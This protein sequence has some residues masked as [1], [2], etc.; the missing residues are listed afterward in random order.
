MKPEYPNLCSPIKIGNVTFRNRMFSAPMGATEITADHCITYRTQG[1]YELRAKGGAAAVTMSELCVH[2]KTD[3]T[4]MIHADPAVS[5]SLGGLAFA[6]DGIRRHGA[7]PSIQ[8]SH[9][10]Q[11]ARPHLPASGEPVPLYGPV[12][13]VLPDGAQ[14]KGLTKMQIEDIVEGYGRTAQ[15]VKRA[16]FEMVMVHVGH[17]WLL[18]Q[19]LSPRFNKREDEYGGSFENR[20]RIVLGA[21]KSI[22]DAVGPGFPIEAR[23]SGDEFIEGGYHI[24]EGCRIAHAVEDYVDLIHVSAG[25]HELSFHRMFPSMFLEHGCNVRL[26]AEVKKHVSKPVATLGA[27]S[28]PKQMEEILA[29]GKADVIYMARQLLADPEFP[30][31]VAA[32]RGD[33]AIKCIRCLYCMA[34]RRVTQTRRCSLEPRIGREFE[35]MNVALAPNPKKVLVVGGGIGGM[36]AA[37]TAASRGHKV[38]LCEKSGELGG[39]LKCEQGIPFKYEMYELTQSFNKLLIKEGVDIRLNTEVDSAYVEKEGVDALIIAV[40]SNPIIPPLPGIDGDNVVIVNN[41]HLEKNK[42][43]DTVAVLGGGLAGSECAIHLAHCGKKVILVEMA[44]KIA[45]DANA[46]H[47]PALLNEIEKYGIDVRTKFKGEFISSEGLT[48]SNNNSKVLIPCDTVIC[49]VGQRPCREVV[50]E[51]RYS[52]PFVRE[53]G[54]CVKAANVMFA[55]YQGYHAAMDL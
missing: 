14:V 40:G 42:V 20:I 39:L 1:F 50:D 44:D 55:T 51:L 54:D 8:L 32:G 18:N 36:K 26:A 13:C 46:L 19:F 31:K 11:I 7:I 41:Y 45:Q 47:R 53:I 21:L 15:F 34:E 16:G 27:L 33:E 52:A 43:G 9:A 25:H 49:A 6:A 4:H 29:S 48:C 30:N 17:G 2:P 10:G 35:D 23:I 22:R 37:F 24:D 3:G 28:D 12:D 38:I 5:G